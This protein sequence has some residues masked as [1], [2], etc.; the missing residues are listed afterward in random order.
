MECSS[1][2]VVGVVLD[3]SKGYGGVEL[4]EL[5]LED[6]VVHGIG[7]G[8]VVTGLF[9][10]FSWLLRSH[11][12]EGSLEARFVRRRHPSGWQIHGC[13]GRDDP[14][15]DL[16]LIRGCHSLCPLCLLGVYS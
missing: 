11:K 3:S 6:W 1:P 12:R 9:R 8:E 5:A 16:D 10:P 14:R 13:E 4:V 2:C 7:G 15:C